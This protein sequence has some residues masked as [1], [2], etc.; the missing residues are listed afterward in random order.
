MEKA[1][2]PLPTRFK[3]AAVSVAMALPTAHEVS[4]F[5]MVLLL[6]VL[7]MVR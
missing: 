6:S 4:T 1:K 3:L 5:A 7:H 2:V